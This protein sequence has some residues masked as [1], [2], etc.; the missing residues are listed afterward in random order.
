[1]YNDNHNTN[2]ATNNSRDINNDNCHNDNDNANVQAWGHRRQSYS[3]H[4]LRRAISQPTRPTTGAHPA[5][6]PRGQEGNCASKFYESYA[7]VVI[8]TTVNDHTPMN[9]D[10]RYYVYYYY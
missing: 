7:V 9:Y 8:I 3:L 2:H 4:F 1:M 6:H 10:Y 5:P